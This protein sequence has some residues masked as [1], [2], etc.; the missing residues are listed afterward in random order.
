MPVAEVVATLTRYARL[1][2]APVR[3]ATTV[4]AVRALSR[5]SRSR[6][7]TTSCTPG[8]WCWRPGRAGRQAIPGIADAV[9]E[10][11]T[12]LTPLTYR[13]PGQLPEGGVLVVGASATG[14]QLAGP[15]PPVWA[16]R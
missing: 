16:P 15:I 11:I 8:Q 14:I 2:C 7:T 13:D 4:H 12:M 3:T 1:V 9:P 6:P 5:A 10:S